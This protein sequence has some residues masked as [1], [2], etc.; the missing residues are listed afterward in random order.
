MF[1]FNEQNCRAYNLDKA[2]S[3]KVDM[4][5]GAYGIFIVYDNGQRNCVKEYATKEQATEA[6]REF[7]NEYGVKLKDFS[8][9]NSTNLF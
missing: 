2:E 1:L 8:G 4:T 3:I 6:F 5:S 9:L 7:M